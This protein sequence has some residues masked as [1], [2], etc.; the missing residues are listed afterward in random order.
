MLKLHYIMIVRMI[1]YIPDF[2][3]P[4]AFT[5]GAQFHIHTILLLYDAIYMKEYL[6]LPC[7]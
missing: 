3:F 6:R 1:G 4:Q 7:A 5:R 2:H